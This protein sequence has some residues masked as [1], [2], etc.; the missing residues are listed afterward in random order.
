MWTRLGVA[1][2]VLPAT[3][4]P[5]QPHSGASGSRTDRVTSLFGCD[6]LLE[7]PGPHQKLFREDESGKKSWQSTVKTVRT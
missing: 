6:R 7:V 1:T 2:G 4:L 3:W 5:N